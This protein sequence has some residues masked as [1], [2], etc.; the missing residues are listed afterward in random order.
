MDIRL[1]RLGRAVLPKG[2]ADGIGS[3][4]D[5]AGRIASLERTQRMLAHRT[6]AEAYGADE[7]FHRHEAKVYSQNG[8][9]GLLLHLFSRIGTTTRTCVEFGFGD[10]SECTTANLVVNWGWQGLYLDGDGEQTASAQRRFAHLLGPEA[11]RARTV[12]AHLTRTNLNDLLG[13]KA[14]DSEPDLLVIDV[15]G[16]DYWLWE[17]LTVLT[18]R[19]VVIEYNAFFGPER[20]VTVP[21]EDAFDRF[22]KHP[23]GVYFGASLRALAKLGETKGYALIGC[24]STGVNAFFVRRDVVEAKLAPVSVA[25]AYRPLSHGFEARPMEAYFEAIAHLPSVQV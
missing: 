15:D 12:H 9:D 25:E 8:E 16:A 17:A 13:A 1:A 6:L 5:L 20:S 18:P 4:L 14:W 23:S 19:A 2:L 3:W 24:D 22:A 21:Y 10:G 11:E 7:G